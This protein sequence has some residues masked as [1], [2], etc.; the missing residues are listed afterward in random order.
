MPPFNV[1]TLYDFKRNRRHAEVVAE[2]RNLL[3]RLERMSAETRIFP[4][5][6]PAIDACLPQGG[7]VSGALHEPSAS[8]ASPSGA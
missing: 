1:P 4:F 2:L 7:L 8:R 3:P 6:L 5:G